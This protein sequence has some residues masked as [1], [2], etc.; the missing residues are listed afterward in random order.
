MRYSPALD[1]ELTENGTEFLSKRNLTNNFENE[2]N[3]RFIDWYKYKNIDDPKGEIEIIE[4]EKQNDYEGFQCF[5]P[6]MYILSL[7]LIPAHCVGKFELIVKFMEDGKGKVVT[8]KIKQISMA[9]WF[10]LFLL[11]SPN[12]E[13]DLSTNPYERIFV[14]IINTEAESYN[15]ATGGE[16]LAPTHNTL[17]LG[18][19]PVLCTGRVK[20][21][22]SIA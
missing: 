8:K 9:G 6:T 19:G 11:L 5:E 3:G 13:Y 7:G 21:N 17:H 12:W 16:Y 1:K 15:R 2:F 10:P 14:D 20:F 22:P 4:V 18:V